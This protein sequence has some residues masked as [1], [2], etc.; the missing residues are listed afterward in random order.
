MF[1]GN[2]ISFYTYFELVFNEIEHIPYICI[3]VAMICGVSYFLYTTYHHF[4]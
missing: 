2:I 1:V 4:Q 3:F